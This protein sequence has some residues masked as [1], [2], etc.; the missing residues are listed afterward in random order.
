MTTQRSAV[1]RNRIDFISS[2]PINWVNSY[3]WAK[4]SKKNACAWSASGTNQLFFMAQHLDSH[5]RDCYNIREGSMACPGF[6]SIDSS[7]KPVWLFFEVHVHIPLLSVDD[8]TYWHVVETN[9]SRISVWAYCC[10][11]KVDELANEKKMKCAWNF[12]YGT[13]KSMW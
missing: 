4:L 9:H 3:F 5:F 8:S 13:K 6:Q 2:K 10:R 11:Q 12:W 7:F 1:Q